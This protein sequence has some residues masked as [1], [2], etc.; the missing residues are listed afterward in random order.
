MST[1]EQLESKQD[2]K[3]ADINLAQWGRRE[4][5]IAE[6][7]MPA[8]MA[9]RE[10]YSESKPLA[11][12]KILGCI[13]MTIQTGVLIETL[14]ALGAEVRWSSC[15]IFST[16]D[17]AAAAIAAA[18]IPVFAWKGETEE[19]Y[20]WCIEQT[21][22]KD[23]QP[24]DANMVLDDGGDLT[25][26]L[27]DSYPQMLEKIHGI[28]EETTTGVHRLQEMLEQGTL[29]VPAVNVNDSVTKSKNDNKYGCRHSLNDAVKRATDHL[30][31][32]KRALV[33]G[34]GDV[35]KG[36]AQSLRQEGMIV[37]I[38]EVDP[39][40]AM[41][42]CMDGFEVVS[43]YNDGVND[44]TPECVNREL[45]AMTDLVVTCTG[46]YN[47]CDANMLSALKSGA[48][49]CNIGHFDN[50]ID[51]AFMRRN[52]EWEEVKPQVHKVYRNQAQNDHL[53]LLSEG[54]L[55]NLGNATGHPSR[56][57]DGS[58]ANQVLAQI[59]LFERRFADL[60]PEMKPS[61]V[62]VE[63]LP[64]KLDEEVAAHMIGG[65]GAVLTRLTSE[66]AKYINVKVEGPFKPETY[67]Y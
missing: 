10:R 6:G 18:G 64:K 26:M 2:Y 9:L 38:T 8:L 37:R 44:G 5:D 41:Q 24:W 31:A 62:K 28:T 59:Y 4:L 30:L 47:V 14:V 40:C 46:N 48:V 39:I 61:A 45:L 60:E 42:A 33:I 43:A 35:G 12:A 23:G 25:Q 57:M 54:R 53:I 58:F 13:H 29:K 22:L 51:T 16:Q 63:V 11:G 55:V 19:E 67:R 7:E 52:W 34:Y 15:N 21:I 27:H 49:V 65:F 3:V 20:E 17:H 36:S 1:A 56:V 66:Q 50:E 32:G